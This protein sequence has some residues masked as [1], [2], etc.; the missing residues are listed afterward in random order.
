LSTATIRTSDVRQLF[1]LINQCREL[2]DA[3]QAPTMHFLRGLARLL[4]S[5]VAIRIDASRVRPG[6]TAVFQGV[7]D[8]GWSSASDRERVYGYVSSRSLDVDP[9][10][11]AVVRHPGRLVTLTRADVISTA[12][13]NQTE[14]RSE[15]HLAAGVDD[16]LLS[17]RRK[18]RRGEAR[19]LVLKRSRSEGSFGESE[20]DLVDLAHGETDWL[21]DDLPV[22][23]TPADCT[24]SRREKETLTLLLTGAS[25]KVVAV[26]LALSR[27]TVHDYV[28]AIYKK[29]GVAS[30]AE[31]MARAVPKSVAQR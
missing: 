2:W 3:G 31:L 25:E 26:K 1:L 24:F 15:V 19:V 30:R 18:P 7:E 13:W 6:G 5:Q 14:V 9:L 11:A 22:P 20:R 12:A 23:N 17:L 4:R 10:T 8:C 27:H 28:K 21:F 29:L 16:S